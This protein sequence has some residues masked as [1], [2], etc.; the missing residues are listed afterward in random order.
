MYDLFRYLLEKFSGRQ[1]IRSEKYQVNQPVHTPKKAVFGT[2]LVKDL[3][4]KDRG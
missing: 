2:T 4:K 3:E 1:E